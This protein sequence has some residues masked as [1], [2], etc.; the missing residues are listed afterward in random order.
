MHGARRSLR[1]ALQSL[2]F[3]QAGYFTAAQAVDLGYSYQGQK[4]H[5]DNG[6]W[7]RIDRGL[8]QLPDWPASP[9]DQWVRWTLW[10]RG[11]GVVSHDSAAL[12]HDLGELDPIR[13]HISVP[14]GFRALDPTVVTHVAD[15]PGTDVLDRGSWRVTTPLRTLLDLASGS[16]TQDQLDSAFASALDHGLTTLRRIRSRA[17]EADDRAA[18]RLERALRA[19]H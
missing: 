17:D 15:L 1:L 2:A 10:S 8:F 6:N 16:T 12:V 5:V 9:D 4:Y 19:P 13:V 11:R 3:G 18:L 7:L 14:D